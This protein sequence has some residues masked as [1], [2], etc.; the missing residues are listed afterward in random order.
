[1]TVNAIRERRL[2]GRLPHDV[3]ES[4]VLARAQS[5]LGSELGSGLGSEWSGGRAAGDGRV[6]W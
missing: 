3:G 5:G 1:M 4:S 2:A 6:G